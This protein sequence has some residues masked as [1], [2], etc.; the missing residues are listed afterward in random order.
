MKLLVL[1]AA[2]LGAMA[3]ASAAQPLYQMPDQPETGLW[4]PT[5][6]SMPQGDSRDSTFSVSV[7][8]VD[9][10]LASSLAVSVTPNR[11]GAG[12]GTLSLAGDTC[13]GAT[14]A[15]HGDCRL[16]FNVRAACAKSGMS[17]WFVTVQS[18]AG[19][20]VTTQVQVANKPGKCD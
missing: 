18:T 10:A 11:P 14:L 20:P 15:Q 17:V 1:F 16:R 2:M 8:N 4:V 19:S 12:A 3:N 9:A 7:R 6:V 13:S 5:I